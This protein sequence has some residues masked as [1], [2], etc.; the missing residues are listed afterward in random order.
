MQ[1]FARPNYRLSRSGKRV[2]QSQLASRTTI[3][4]P[5]LLRTLPQHAMASGNE[6]I[7][8]N[9]AVRSLVSNHAMRGPR[10][11]QDFS[12]ELI[13]LYPQFPTPLLHSN[14]RIGIRFMTTDS[15]T[16]PPSK[17]SSSSPTTNDAP[18]V[19]QESPSLQ[20][21]PPPPIK[22]S[23]EGSS[24]NDTIKGLVERVSSSVE[25]NIGDRLSVYGIV[26]LIGVI[27]VAPM[28]VQYVLFVLKTDA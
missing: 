1:R 4:L 21:P 17:D 25:L 13:P 2:L 8:H 14:R 20:Q 12:S 15:K 9:G 23:G 19:K 26:A 11:A 10:D 22:G 18:L 16:P 6:R 28:V 24:S 5:A 27:I 7:Q 3:P